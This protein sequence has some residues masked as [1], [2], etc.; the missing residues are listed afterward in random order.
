M[1]RSSG[2]MAAGNDHVAPK[3]RDALRT[4]SNVVAMATKSHPVGRPGRR[5][6]A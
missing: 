2:A 3:L 1:G 4:W 6:G 5:F